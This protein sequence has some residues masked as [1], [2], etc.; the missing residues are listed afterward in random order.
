MKIGPN[1]QQPLE[2]GNTHEHSPQEKDKILQLLELNE[3]EV[4]F[5]LMNKNYAWVH[6]WLEK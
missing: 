3:N 2:E 1:A 4:I 5:S 6:H